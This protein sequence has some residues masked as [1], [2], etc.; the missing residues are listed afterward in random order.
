M[1][2]TKS[3]YIIDK[4]SIKGNI[5]VIGAGALGSQVAQNL[6]RLNLASKMIVYDM[7]TVEEKN[8]NNQ[9]YLYEHIGMA[10]VDAMRDLCEKIDPNVKLRIKNKK[11]ESIRT[12]TDDIVILGID[13]FESRA[14]ILKAIEGNPLVISG[15]ISS[16]GGNFEIVRGTKNYQKLSKEYAALESGQEYD[17]NDMTPCGSPISINHRIGYAASLISDAV[18]QYHDNLE[19]QNRNIIFDTPN[20][21]LIEQIS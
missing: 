3:F 17:E 9:A 12:K 4:D 14:N 21:I 7:D 2:N 5:H 19:P 6:I 20:L 8:L 13:N 18:I 11:V 1:I 16:I 15:G 10:K